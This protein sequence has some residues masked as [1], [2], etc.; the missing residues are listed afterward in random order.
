M[1]HLIETPIFLFYLIA[2][3]AC[4]PV[5]INLGMTAIALAPRA[6]LLTTELATLVTGLLAT[7]IAALVVTVLSVT[8]LTIFHVCAMAAGI[9]AAWAPVVLF[10]AGLVVFGWVCLVVIVTMIA[11]AVAMVVT[12]ARAAAAAVVIAARAAAALDLSTIIALSI[13]AGL[14]AVAP[15]WCLLVL[16][17]QLPTL[18]LARH[19]T[20]RTTNTQSSARRNKRHVVPTVIRQRGAT[21]RIC[22]K[23]A[24]VAPAPTP[25]PAPASFSTTTALVISG[26]CAMA[27]VGRCA[28]AA[29]I[30]GH[31][32]MAAVGR[33]AMAAVI[34]GGL[35]AAAAWAPTA[36]F[37]SLWAAAAVTGFVFF[38]MDSHGNDGTEK[39]STNIDVAEEGCYGCYTAVTIN[40]DATKQERNDIGSK[41]GVVATTAVILPLLIPV[42]SPPRSHPPSPC[43]AASPVAITDTARA[44]NLSLPSW[45]TS[46]PIAAACSPDELN[47]IKVWRASK[48][49]ADAPVVAPSPDTARASN[50]SSTG[51]PM[52]TAAACSPAEL[53]RIKAWRARRAWAGAA[54]FVPTVPTVPEDDC[55]EY[56]YA[57]GY[58]VVTVTA[59]AES[60]KMQTSSV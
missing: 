7:D 39:E 10:A 29:V 20:G 51:H 53:E 23:G 9:V 45:R 34:S 42:S 50:L 22:S 43:A 8:A 19:V 28:M 6:C 31:G 38:A 17:L 56:S 15:H 44:S 5:A 18:S 12:A 21:E 60:V 48:D 24:P 54:P 49:V 41:E 2:L 30:S 1:A 35:A 13:D 25:K 40:L 37:F 32:A 27:A 16:Q 57:G 4:P 52:P 3:V 46:M 36:L 58:A 59:P 55:D 33:C 11:A 47:R 26:V 14:V